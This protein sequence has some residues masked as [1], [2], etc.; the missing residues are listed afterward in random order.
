LEKH[1]Y[2]TSR[3]IFESTD[4]PDETISEPPEQDD[5]EPDY[6]LPI[7]PDTSSC[8]SPT[9]KKLTCQVKRSTLTNW[10]AVPTSVAETANPCQR[11][12]LPIKISPCPV[13]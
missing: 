2:L 1:V 5:V 6:S 3:Q 12:K 11:K 10:S 13:K 7:H 9:E 4:R 8:Q